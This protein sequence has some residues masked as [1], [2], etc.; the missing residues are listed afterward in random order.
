MAAVTTTAEKE[1]RRRKRK[2]RDSR[3]RRAAR[4]RARTISLRKLPRPLRRLS[5]GYGTAGN[6]GEIC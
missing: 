1:E 4:P 3:Q 2:D 5:H 6:I